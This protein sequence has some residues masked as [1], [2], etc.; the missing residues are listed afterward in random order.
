MITT[1]YKQSQRITWDFKI[2]TKSPLHI[3]SGEDDG[4][5]SDSKK[6]I[7]IMY[8]GVETPYIPGSSLK[9]V[10]RSEVER[11]LRSS[12][13]LYACNPL[14]NKDACGQRILKQDKK[15]TKKSFNQLDSVLKTRIS[16]NDDGICVACQMFGTHMFRGSVL[17]S[18]ALPSS[19]IG[20]NV[21]TSTAISRKNGN[22]SRGALFSNE[23]VTPNSEFT[24]KIQI[25]GNDTIHIAYLAAALQN[26]NQ[27]FVRLG[28][29]STKGFGEVKIDIIRELIFQNLNINSVEVEKTSNFLK[30]YIKKV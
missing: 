21:K 10:I 11:L 14:D 27:G 26:I 1:H 29:F 28:G 30:E 8:K 24:G 25:L 5:K 23:Y 13:S 18:D 20:I 17:I 12:N 19:S 2:T 7:R 3:G 9:G 4:L 16:K 6:V 22:V 15:I